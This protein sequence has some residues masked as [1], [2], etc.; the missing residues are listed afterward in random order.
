M[1]FH[2]AFH[3]GES[4]DGRPRA[5]VVVLDSEEDMWMLIHAANKNDVGDLIKRDFPPEVE[6]ARHKLERLLYTMKKGGCYWIEAEIPRCFMATWKGAERLLPRFQTPEVLHSERRQNDEFDDL[7]DDLKQARACGTQVLRREH[8]AREESSESG[9]DSIRRT[10]R[11]R[12]R[13]R[14]GRGG[15]GGGRGAGSMSSTAREEPVQMDINSP[16]PLQ[17]TP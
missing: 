5:L 1:K 3:H 17:P 11:G 8:L 12:P 13:R 15:R 2:N 14:R 9:G 7:P 16:Q 10:S 4:V 6:E